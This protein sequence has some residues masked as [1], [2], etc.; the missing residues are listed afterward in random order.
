MHWSERIGNRI[1][2]RDLHILLAVAKAGSMGKAAAELAV[3]QPVVSKAVSDLEYSLGVRLLDRSPQGVE[4][5]DHGRAL[6]DCGLSVFD[7]LRRGVA[8]LEF[9]SDPA[10]GELRLG[11]TEPLAA[12][13]VGAVIERLAR[14][15][16][17]IR[18]QV[19]TADPSA[20]KERELRQRTIELAV[21]PAE[22]LVP[23]AE[24]DVD[25][26]FDDRQIIVVGGKSR[27]ARRRH[28]SLDA[29][30]GEAWILPPPDTIIG[31]QI[32]SAFRAAGIDPPRSQIETFSVPLCYRLIATGR[33]VTMLPASMVSLGGDLPLRFLRVASPAVARPTGIVSLRN[34][35]RSSLAEL[36]VGEARKLAGT[37]QG[38][39]RTPAAL[40][41]PE[42]RDA[43]RAA[44]PVRDA[45]PPRT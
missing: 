18:F 35:T 20:L 39:N 5:T 22:G 14:N 10:A 31:A 6:L 4:P 1:K 34:R 17:R 16:Q 21:T 41:R 2:L 3:S 29:L 13:F 37:L 26:L 7:D 33:F 42:R 27:W 25:I 40:G 28:V 32:A 44:S 11:C 24:I 12:G 38:Q 9:L 8:A 36:F 30:M 45:H 15:F 23:D 43:F 19:V